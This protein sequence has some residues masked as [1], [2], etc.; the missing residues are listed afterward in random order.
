MRN[1]IIHNVNLYRTIHTEI[2]KTNEN[3]NYILD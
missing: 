1:I 3:T 2:R